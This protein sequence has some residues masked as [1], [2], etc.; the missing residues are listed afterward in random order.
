MVVFG[1]RSLEGGEVIQP[2]QSTGVLLEGRDRLM[3]RLMG[4]T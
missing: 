1:I 3:A 4:S 2:F